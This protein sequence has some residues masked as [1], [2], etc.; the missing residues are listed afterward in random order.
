MLFT[1][2]LE[3]FSLEA[4]DGRAGSLHDFYWKPGPVLSPPGVARTAGA[5]K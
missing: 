4:P 2:D 1:R 3:R 5:M